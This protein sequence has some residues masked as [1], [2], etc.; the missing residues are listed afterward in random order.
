[1]WLVFPQ[2]TSQGWY[3]IAPLFEIQGKTIE[4]MKREYSYEGLPGPSQIQQFSHP[5]YRR[6][7]FS[8]SMLAQWKIFVI[9]S[10]KALG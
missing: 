2:Q 4:Q 5:D 8:G 7:S 6:V 3:E 1:M 9:T 10:R